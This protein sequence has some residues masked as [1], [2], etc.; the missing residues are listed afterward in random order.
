MRP[1]GQPRRVCLLLA[2]LSIDGLAGD[3]LIITQELIANMLGARREGVTEAGGTHAPYAG[4]RTYMDHYGEH[5][6][7]TVLDGPALFH[8]ISRVY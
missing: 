2:L 7:L 8:R 6:D 3:E 4:C 5:N 1:L